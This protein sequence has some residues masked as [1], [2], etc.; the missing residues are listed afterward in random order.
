MRRGTG[1]RKC[2]CWDNVRGRFKVSV[3]GSVVWFQGKVGVVVGLG[4]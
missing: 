2:R 3:M 1:G 4:V